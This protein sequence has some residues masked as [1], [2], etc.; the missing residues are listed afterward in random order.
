MLRIQPPHALRG[1]AFFALAGLL[2]P[3][4][5]LAKDSKNDKKPKPYT[6]IITSSAETDSGMFNVHRVDEKLYFEIP[7]SL[8]GRDILLV[9]RIA[10]VP[11]DLVGGFMAAGHKTGEQVLRWERVEDRILVRKISYQNVADESL[12]IHLSVV[13]NNFAPIIASFDVA[14]EGPKPAKDEKKKSSSLSDRQR[15]G[16]E[17]DARKSASSKDEDK[18]K[19]KD[20][21]EEENGD[22]TSLKTVVIDVTDF[23][24]KDIPA[25]SGLNKPVREI[26]KVGGLDKDRS[27]LNY[28]HAYPLNVEVRHTLTYSASQ[29]P[30]DVGTQTLSMEMHQSMVLL[31]EEP[32]RHRVFDPRVRYFTVSQ[33]NY[34]L[35]KQKAAEQTF[36]GRWR[37]EPSDPEAY[38]RGELVEPVKPIVYYLDPATPE[39]WRDAVRLGIEDWQV[40]FE[41][42]GF[43][44]AIIAKD[45]PTAEED[46]EWTGEDVRYSVVRWAAKEVRNAMGP[47]VW[48]PR[49]GEIIESDIVWYHNHMRTYRNR[50]MIET[51]A[52][53]PLARSLPIDES[54]MQ[55][56]MRAVIAHEVGHALGLPHNMIASSSFPVESLRDPEFARRMGVAPT[57]MEYARQNY[58]AQPGDGL[59][60]TDFIRQIG[61]YDHYSINW[62]YRVLPDAETPDDEKSV[63]DGW[64]RE[65]ADDPMYRYAPQRG[66]LSVDP[67]IQTEDLGDDPV[68]ASGYA[69]AKGEEI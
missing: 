12:P 54:L 25:I 62:G 69:M 27:F 52:A 51:G 14:A 4:L 29:P 30:T 60:G 32:M 63:L 45:P 33:I 7:D 42:A 56:A 47:S 49:S 57:I 61:P 65:K 53:N 34:G 36:I 50:L 43:K 13:R 16:L 5:S 38:A 15:N 21:D 11:A 19:D 68:K 23:F 64:I 3:A 44:N 28:A 10:Q 48:D 66:G 22:E 59:T 17:R 20:E 55:E 67:R 37:L 46:P 26:Y 8:L 40:A 24:L 9:S 39:K 35:D 31:P 18:D 1:L 6:E 2:I 58:I 41:T